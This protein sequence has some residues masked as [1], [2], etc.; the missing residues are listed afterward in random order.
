M[1]SFH[2][3]TVHLRSAVSYL[4]CP[5]PRALFY[6]SPLHVALFLFCP[7]IPSSFHPFIV[8]CTPS[9]PRSLP[10]PSVPPS[11]LLRV[12]WGLERVAVVDIDVH[13]GNGTA[14]LLRG[15]PRSFFASVHMIYGDGNDGH[16]DKHDAFSGKAGV[17]AD[18]EG[19][20]GF[21]PSLLGTTEVTDNYVSVGVFPPHPV[22]P[23]KPERNYFGR[24]PAASKTFNLA[25]SEIVD[26]SSE[27]NENEG[28]D[29]ED[30]VEENADSVD[31]EID[32]GVDVDTDGAEL[33]E[34]SSSSSKMDL[35][36]DRP[37]ECPASPIRSSS[38][39][40]LLQS[41]ETVKAEAAKVEVEAETKAESKGRVKGSPLGEFRGAA[42]FRQAL[43]DV[44]IP[45][46]ENFNP[47][48][49]IISGTP[50]FYAVPPPYYCSPLFANP[51][52]SL[53]SFLF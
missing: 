49:L 26:E 16:D 42:G 10:L 11:P 37:E 31:V 34:S 32:V 38:T 19:A 35:A 25:K 18:E 13:F 47:Q 41:V 2:S 9:F 53:S 15:D 27:K 46:M 33:E 8:P 1:S 29:V 4:R 44:I 7:H 48:L 43:L 21:Y 52:L 22:K 23:T 6:A 39:E 14:E 36:L 50:D 30:T 20:Y 24:N 28:E 51:L 3:A 45:Q 17:R 40:N 12:R 5:V